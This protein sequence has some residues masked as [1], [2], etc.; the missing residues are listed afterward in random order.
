MYRCRIFLL[1]IFIFC[2]S[3]EIFAQKT[4]KILSATDS[5]KLKIVENDTIEDDEIQVGYG[6]VLR[7]RNTQSISTITEEDMRMTINANIQ[8]AIQ[9]RAA[10]VNVVNSGE[11]GGRYSAIYIRGLS[12]IYG[13]NQPL[14]VVNGFP[15][16]TDYLNMISP[17]D[18]ERIDILK[19][20]ASC[21]IYGSRGANGVILIKTK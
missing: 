8:Q 19:D 17:N 6:T 5:S 16:T 9:G 15:T 12:S 11:P 3:V 4:S 7:S 18:I 20:A 10:G 2:I 21:A 1:S 14:I 13:N